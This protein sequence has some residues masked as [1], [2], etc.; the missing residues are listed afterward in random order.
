MKKIISLSII[1]A[2]ATA[3][4][5]QIV[6]MRELLVVFYGNELSISFILAGWLISGALGSAVF[7]K[8]ADRIRPNAEAFS[9]CQMTLGSLLIAGIAAVK[10]IKVFLGVNPGE[11]VGLFPIMAASF[12]ILAPICVLMGFIFPLGCS[13]YASRQSDGARGIGTV[14]ILEAIGSIIGGTV[15]SFILIR[16]F[17]ALHIAAILA[18]LNIMAAFLLRSVIAR[19]DKIFKATGLF[20]SVVI[21]ALWSFGGLKAIERYSLQKQWQGYEILD[22]KNSIYGNILIARRGE[23]YSLFNNGLRL[24]TIPDKPNSEEAVHLAL[25]EHKDPRRVLLIGGGSGGLVGEILK[26]RVE[27]VDYVELDPSIIKIS[28]N[29]LPESYY[30]ALKDTRV[31]IKNTDGRFF[32]KN[33]IELYDCIIIHTGDPYTAEVNR[34]YTSEFFNEVKKALKESGLVSFGLTSSESYISKSLAEFLRSIYA[35]LRSVFSEVIVIPGETAYFLASDSIGSLTYDHKILEERTLAR[36]LDT[37][38]VRDYYLFSKLSPEEIAYSEKII[39]GGNGAV[40]NHDSR[41]VAYYYGLIFW[42]TL[43]RNSVFSN[44]L[45]SVTESVIW[46]FI[47]IFMILLAVI[48]ITRRWSFKRSSLMAVMTGGFSSMAFQL[49]ILLTFQTMYGYLFYKLGIILTAFMAGLAL[50]AVFVIKFIPET[51]RDRIFLMAV[52]GDF[53][54]FSVLLGAVFSRF[55]PDPLFPVLSV[56]AGSIGG[57]QFALASRVLLG[58]KKDAG[59]VGGLSYGIDLF[60]SFLGALLT[61]IFLIPILGI[62]KTCFA[63]ALINLSALVL[64]FINLRVEE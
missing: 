18:L 9:L 52:Q 58:Q 64:L 4:A 59:R 37:Q 47:G 16:S 50:G 25:L 36:A 43:F 61:G 57:A 51:K 27:K 2:G 34:Y 33:A 62:P 6:Y 29:N 53:I 1:L 20:L 26:H 60:G 63:I 42:T 14:Y 56:I 19:N 28:E 54:I 22:T 44:I 39:K 12:A 55:C 32:V 23:D 3:M 17:D 48:S 30:K 49:L 38:Y 11:I 41:P 35:T 13:I 7:G 5:S 46:R 15:T 24:Y 40:I 8:Y 21:I 45:R 10:F 31:S